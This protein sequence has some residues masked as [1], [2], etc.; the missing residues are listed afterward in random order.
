MKRTDISRATL[1]RIPIY[2]HYLR[3]LPPNTETISA[4]CIANTLSF[5]AVQVRKDLGTLCGF[6]KPKTGYHRAQ[7]MEHLAQYLDC[8]NGGAVIIG[9][10]QLGRALLDYDGFAGFGISILAAFDKKAEAA[11]RSANDKP[12]LPVRALSDFCSSHTVTLGIIAVPAEAAQEICN[13]LYANGI[14]A[15][16]CFAPCRLYHPADAVVQYENLALSLA[17]LKMQRQSNAAA[18]SCAQAKD[19]KG[20]GKPVFEERNGK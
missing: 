3:S 2:L 4:T 18:C 10:G 1:G 6:G 19:E 7:L 15:I 5:G 13:L 16:W 17:Y 20:M 9:A 8:E 14:R 12:I 11:E